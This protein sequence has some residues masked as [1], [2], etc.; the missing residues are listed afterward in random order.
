MIRG[1]II[2]AGFLIAILIASAI[3]SAFAAPAP[4]WAVTMAALSGC[5]TILAT[6]LASS[7]TLHSNRIIATIP[8]TVAISAALSEYY[9]MLERYMVKGQLPEKALVRECESKMTAA[10][11]GVPLLP[12]TIR[13][14]FYQT[15]QL[16]T[17]MLETC[18]KELSDL[19]DADGRATVIKKSW[20]TSGKEFG[21]RLTAFQRAINARLVLAK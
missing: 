8:A 17:V 18:E 7:A 6:F 5:V 14:H 20:S 2:I 19:G 13:S 16:A 10:E 11:S 21:E 12:E 9:R 15:W 4:V 3:L 1:V